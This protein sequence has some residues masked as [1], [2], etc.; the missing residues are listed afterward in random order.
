MEKKETS[1]L[2]TLKWLC[3]LSQ[4]QNMSVIKL[5]IIIITKKKLKPFKFILFTSA[6][7]AYL[8]SSVF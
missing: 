4:K 1:V 5:Q 7:K 3:F 6:F 8:S 2:N